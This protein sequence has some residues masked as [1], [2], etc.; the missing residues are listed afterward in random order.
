MMTVKELTSTMAFSIK[1]TMYVFVY[2]S[3]WSEKDLKIH[4]EVVYHGT[5]TVLAKDHTIN[6]SVLESEVFSF[7]CD[8]HTLII[9]LK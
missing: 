1:E 2:K 9:S 8:C 4:E 3:K 6:K 7:R 5:I